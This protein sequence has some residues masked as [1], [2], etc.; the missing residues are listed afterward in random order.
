[1]PHVEIVR[2]PPAADDDRANDKFQLSA[3]PQDSD[4][5]KKS[6]VVFADGGRK[7]EPDSSDDED[8]RLEDKLITSL[9]KFGV[10]R[11]NGRNPRTK[12]PTDPLVILLKPNFDWREA[13][14]K[15][16]ADGSVGGLGTR[17][18]INSDSQL[19]G[20]QFGNKE[21]NMTVE[22]YALVKETEDQKALRALLVGD[23]NSAPQ[24]DCIPVPP[25]ETDALQ[26]DV[27]NFSSMTWAGWTAGLLQARKERKLMRWLMEPYPPKSRPALLAIGA[28]EQD[29]LYDG[30]KK[31][32]WRGD[33]KRYIPLVKQE[34]SREESRNESTTV[35]RS[36]LR[37]PE[38]RRSSRRDDDCGRGGDRDYR[39]RRD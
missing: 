4:D 24:I 33:E 31:Q 5:E 17:D 27:A 2:K 23:M 35:S 25:S 30:T 15:C 34:S 28:K 10:Q 6:E 26:Q 3:L 38:R 18:I 32:K 37:S 22:E 39:R 11:V 29:V 1:M 7:D 9:N 14:R 21:R 13:A 16:R 8:K 20:I 19:S 36:T 12:V